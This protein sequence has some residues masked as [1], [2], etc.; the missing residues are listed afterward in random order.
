M[1]DQLQALGKELLTRQVRQLAEERLLSGVAL[2]KHR[3]K[4]T[5]ARRRVVKLALILVHI[6]NP[7]EDLYDPEEALLRGINEDAL[8]NRKQI[9]PDKP[10]S[11]RK[12]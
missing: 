10:N 1:S 4:L 8:T 11:L 2:V 3:Q 7:F 12:L 9:A 5:K 6:M